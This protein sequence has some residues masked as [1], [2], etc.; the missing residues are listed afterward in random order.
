MPHFIRSVP[1]DPDRA[2][3]SYNDDYEAVTGRVI[4]RNGAEAAVVETCL[5]TLGDTEATPVKEIQQAFGTHGA[6]AGRPD[7]EN[8]AAQTLSLVCRDRKYEP[9]VRAA[10]DRYRAKPVDIIREFDTG[11]PVV[12]KLPGRHWVSFYLARALGNLAAPESADALMAALTESPPEGAAGHPDPLGP[13]VL[14]LHQDLTP[15]WRAAVAW[16]LGRIGDPRAVPVLL[17]VVGDLRNAPDTRH[18]A[19]EAVGAL[20]GPASADAIRRLAANYPEVS[21]RKALLRAA[22]SLAP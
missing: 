7:P 4:R 14:F 18:A 22:T 3:F 16:A 20:A 9:R 19:A 17:E 10:F 13:G 2:L 6:W 15:C 11:I 5:A 12:H 1:T 21:T 8:R